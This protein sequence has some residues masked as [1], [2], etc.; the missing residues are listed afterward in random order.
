MS[1]TYT[2]TLPNGEERTIIGKAA[3]KAYL[4]QEGMSLFYPDGKY[5]WLQDA[6]QND[7]GAASQQGAPSKPIEDAGEKIGGARKDRWKERGLNLED[8]DAM[9]E[10]EG[11]ELATKANVWKPDYEALASAAEPV[12]AAMVKTIYDKLAA[13]PAKNTPEGRRQYVQMMRIVRDVY[14]EA[15]GPEAVKNAYLEI[16]KRAGVNTTD[17]Q[18]KAAAREL[19]FSVYKGRSDPFVL[20]YNEAS[21]AKKLV[22]DGFPV[23]AEP[24]KSRLTVGRPEGGSGTTER[25]FAMYTEL[26]A[27]VGTPLTR[28]QIA[29][30]FFRV[31][32]KKN[33][34]VAFAPTKE[35]AEAAAKTVY[36]RDMK[37]GKDEKPEP[38][39]PH[40]DEMKRENLPQ[41]IDRDVTS[42]DFVRDLGF[43]GVEFGNWSAQDERQRILNMAY[44]GLMDLAEIMGVPPK[45]MSL[46][47]TLGMAFGARGG[48]KFAAHYEPGKLVINMTKIRGGGSMAHEWAHAMDHYFGELDKPDAYTTQARGASGWMSEDQYQGVP[49]KRM[50]KIGG[51]W[52]NVEKM[53]LDNLR[54]ELASAFDE[55][56]RALFQQQLT[57]AEMVRSQEL[58]LERTEA[59]A[60]K[61]QDAD[62]KAM[63]Q[64][65]AENKRQALEELRQ[66][67]DDKM[68]AGR[69]RSEYAAQAQALSGKSTNGYWT[70]PT[71]MFARA[72]ESWVFDKV[73]A[74]GA[75]SDYLVH[76]VEEDRF[77]GGGY[78]GNPYP[79]GAERARINAAFDK[80]ADTIQ[81]RETDRGV[82]M[83]SR[84]AAGAN[85]GVNWVES[86]DQSA[87]ASVARAIRASEGNKPGTYEYT[88]VEPEYQRPSFGDRLG[89]GPKN[90]T[91]AVSQRARGFE[92][93]F[94]RR[95][96]FVRPNPGS[97]SF[98]NG[99]IL[100]KR[101]P[102]TIYINIDANVNLMSILGHEFYEGLLVQNPT[103]HQWFVK[104]AR[105]Q[106][107]DGAMQAYSDK[108]AK[109]GDT[110]D[111]AGR[112]KELL[113][114]F[115]GDAL[116]DP[117]F[118]R[119]LEQADQNK[120]RQLIRAFRN[121]LI[122]TLSKMRA[123]V[124]GSGLTG[125]KTLGSEQ[126][127]KDVQ[128][129]RDV[130]RAVIQ[131]ANSGGS[132]TTYLENGGVMFS[133]SG[134]QTQTENFKRW[135]GDSKVVDADGKPLVVYH[136]TKGD[137]STPRMNAAGLFFVTPDKTSVAEFTDGR[138]GAQTM[139][140]YASIKKPFDA[141]NKEAIEAVV[142]EGKKK[143]WIKN[144]VATLS[145]D[146]G[147][148]PISL[149]LLRAGDYIA[150]ESREVVNAIKALGHDGIKITERGM[151]N[152]A[153]FGPEQIK[154]AI[155]NNGDFDPA[156]P[157][158]RYSRKFTEVKDQAIQRINQAMNHPGE[159]H[160]W[161]KTVGTMNNLAERSPAFKRVFDAAQGF[162]DDVSHYATDAA[163]MAPKLLPQLESIKD[164]TKRPISAE[165]N[166][167]IQAPIFEGTLAWARDRDGA[168]V[169]VE[170]LEKVAATL[171][172]DQKAQELLRNNAIDPRVLR[173]WRGLPLE[174]YERFVSARYATKLMAPGIVWTDSE[175][176]TMF[177]LNDGQIDLYRE[178]RDATDRSLD[179]MARADMLRFGGEDLKPLKKKVMEAADAREAVRIIGD[180]LKEVAQ[181]TPSREGQMMD[182]MKGVNDRYDRL[183]SLQDKG[184]APLTR[185]GEYTVDVV[186]DGVRKYFSM[187]ETKAE[188]NA[189]AEQMRGEYGQD[190]VTQGTMSKQEH[191]LMQGINPETLE[192]F[193]NMLGL[194]SDGDTARDQV[195]QE[196][197]RKAKS[198]RSAMKRLIHRKGVAGYSDDVGRVLASFVYSNARQT[199]AGLNMGELGEAV[200]AIPKGQGQL[201]DAAIA[202]A[203]Y[204]KNPKEEGQAIRGLLFGQFLGG[205]VAAASLNLLQPTQVTFPW[206][207]QFTSVKNAAGQL[208]KASKNM[209]T[210]GYQYE[211]DLAKALKAAEDDGTVSPQEVHQL[212]RQAGG[213]GS[214]RVKDGTPVGNL[215]AGAANT[216]E[217]V[218][219]G[220]GSLFG[221]A[222]QINRRMTFIASYRIAKENGLSNP[223]EF[224]RKAVVETQFVYSKANKPKWARSAIGGTLFT[225]KTFSI[226]YLELMHRMWN[227]GEPGSP[228][229]AAGRRAVAIS[230]AMLFLVAGMSGLPFAED[231]EDLAT[232]IGQMMGYNFDA[233]QKRNEFVRS[234]VGSQMADFLDRG[235]SGIP[236]VP[237]DVSGRLGLG[238]L[239]PGT[240][241][242]QPK[243]SADRD[244]WEILGPVGSLVRDWRNAAVA[245][246]DGNIGATVANLSP[247]AI[248]NVMKGYDMGVTGMYRDQK[249]YKVLDTTMLEAALKA[250]GF[251]P[252]S[253]AKEQDKTAAVKQAIDYYNLKAAEIRSLWAAGIF[254]RDP[255][256]VQQA[257]DTIAAWNAKN[258]DLP[259]RVY[260]PSVAKR[261]REMAKPRSE[262]VVE[263]APQILRQSFRDRVEEAEEVD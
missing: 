257:R 74:M 170:D 68:Y 174:K 152:F 245:L 95:V 44:D 26:S 135:F 227:A 171:T 6:N 89:L 169:L 48:G 8:L 261:V 69:G 37:G 7:A 17:P 50:E 154:S 58:D 100:P 128:A 71:E 165:D 47:G 97:P 188:A 131:K 198:N 106:M 200:D 72:F 244:F 201:K 66:D 110:Q 214:M 195:F 57:K 191:L 172:A 85:A 256:K 217:I 238:N 102:N 213:G 224:A 52:K 75:R 223:E 34:T 88:I 51:E 2:L 186:V 189:M 126:Y 103:L 167:A 112:L 19:L 177:N 140:M 15:K 91:D 78:K 118:R 184:Y 12:T 25:G 180:Y 49:R 23:K 54:P 83:F 157:D 218:K 125:D 193:G 187:F 27:E 199:A 115:T 215:R 150:I 175:L 20:G 192:L 143:G 3:M 123:R 196:Y 86:A 11:A 204:V 124:T 207:T 29:E 235:F 40:L 220:W 231:A 166:R 137:F 46:N 241:M 13:R 182:I 211:A 254:E 233:K 28:E 111:D 158:I 146:S 38:V 263:T 107:N 253:V 101:D 87:A 80:L 181:A 168:P 252:S 120:F 247:V 232:A 31:T 229:R 246:G 234:I 55:V 203:E 39:R 160:W 77:A 259:M 164:V 206:L 149:S 99:F 190:A 105:L 134:D 173:A 82:A 132:L 10:A 32:D 98:F 9:T 240:A 222:E 79:T 24:W 1:C 219:F 183:K 43:R 185:F 153:V 248:R 225:F 148:I 151:V 96:V 93:A 230:M 141:S 242:L 251:Q 197:L 163:D 41:R 70:R 142:A 76:G 162:L 236:G 67:P 226:S 216:L 139:A 53:R 239:I 258:P 237:L 250:I 127:F 116:A 178:F 109:L 81:T 249:G 5:P 136:G 179:N 61:E 121:F 260:M 138:A 209:A 108:L 122:Q 145:Y 62:L 147:S 133:R 117:E 65:M 18:A 156:N 210:K 42:E 56:M 104:Q 255:D 114:D 4:V 159:L 129:L 30:G 14:T 202:L 33:K 73:T 45:A 119:S 16:R 208:A 212:M 221:A 130:L 228:E 243:P 161:H 63:Y 59:L 64:R 205:S 36:E 21:K 155:G 90:L 113:A 262:R 144:D 176:R 22:E 94:G 84:G 60:Q 35:D 92:S 194:E